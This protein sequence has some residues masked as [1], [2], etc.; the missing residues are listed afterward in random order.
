MYSSLSGLFCMWLNPRAWNSSCMI[1]LIP[2]QNPLWSIF[3]KPFKRVIVLDSF[4]Y[5]TFLIPPRQ[6]PPVQVV[7]SNIISLLSDVFRRSNFRHVFWKYDIISEWRNLT[8]MW[9][10]YGS[11]DI[12]KNNLCHGYCYYRN[13]KLSSSGIGPAPFSISDVKT[14]KRTRSYTN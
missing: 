14:Q 5:R 13:S 9:E 3:T 11:F 2:L 10:L 1:S 12:S 6:W 4:P 7:I 8:S